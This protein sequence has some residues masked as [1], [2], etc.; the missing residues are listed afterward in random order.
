MLKSLMQQ[1]H[2]G[3]PQNEIHK[4]VNAL[5]LPPKLKKKIAI[6][7]HIL[8][9][10]HQSDLKDAK[11]LYMKHPSVYG[12]NSL[13]LAHLNRNEFEFIEN[14]QSKDYPRHPVFYNILILYYTRI[15]DIPKAKQVIQKMNEAQV[16]VRTNELNVL[17]QGLCKQRMIQH[18]IDIFQKLLINNETIDLITYNTMIHHC[19]THQMYINAFFY[20]DLMKHSGLVFDTRSYNLLIRLYASVG[21]MKQSYDLL[22]ELMAQGLSPDI[23][24]FSS[25]MT[26]H[27]NNNEASQVLK[28]HQNLPKYGLVSDFVTDTIYLRGL[29]AQK[30][31]ADVI[32][33]TMEKLMPFL[34]QAKTVHHYFYRVLE[35]FSSKGQT[36]RCLTLFEILKQHD[37]NCVYSPM[38]SCFAFDGK[39]EKAYQCLLESFGQEA[40]VNQLAYHALMRCAL[41]Q[42]PEKVESLY[43]LMVKR[44]LEPNGFSDFLLLSSLM[45]KPRQFKLLVKDRLKDHKLF[46]VCFKFC[47]QNNDAVLADQVW[48]MYL[49]FCT[50]NGPVRP[51]TT[52]LYIRSC[53]LKNQ[54]EKAREAFN[55]CPES[56]QA[57]LRQDLSSLLPRLAIDFLNI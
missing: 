27:L 20:A 12:L 39:F 50:Q 8:N 44:G 35:Y 45:K 54:Q 30:A 47:I 6:E 38:I 52:A 11:K 41:L 40:Q 34:A 25:L 16:K 33:S 17:L 9:R 1:V 3:L 57:K 48:S 4:L 15:G 56:A 7:C 55:Q 31:D 13:L 43:H 2:R 36:E 5:K 10:I 46:N 18:A 53:L 32:W 14:I 19:I 21:D 51:F 22:D 24:T 42:Q 49:S 37:V 26:G 28:L 23:Y 29:I